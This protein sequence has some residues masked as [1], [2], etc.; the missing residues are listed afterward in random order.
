ME[1]IHGNLLLREHLHCQLIEELRR[2]R[3][4]GAMIIA[5]GRI[6]ERDIPDNNA[7]LVDLGSEG[8]NQ[9]LT[10]TLSIRTTDCPYL[11]RLQHNKAV[12]VVVSSTHLPSQSYSSK[13]KRTIC[14]LCRMSVCCS[15]ACQ[16]PPIVLRSGESEWHLLSPRSDPNE[17]TLPPS[18]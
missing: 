8:L 3:A 18:I 7:T 6:G 1:S 17:H 2:Q 16:D 11:S 12:H 15:F 14:L 4:Q 13:K 10:Q 5:I 9:V